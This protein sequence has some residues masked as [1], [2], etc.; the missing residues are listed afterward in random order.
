MED[1]VY[2]ALNVCYQVDVS[3]YWDVKDFLA[4]VCYDVKHETMIRVEA[5]LVKK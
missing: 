4:V 1:V 2:F 3:H 5:P